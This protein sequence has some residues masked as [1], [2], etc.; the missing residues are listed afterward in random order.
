M[1]S[2]VDGRFDLIIIDPPF[3]WFAPRDPLEASM[4]DE[5]YG[6][7]GRFFAGAGEYLAD[8][9]RVLVFF[10]TSG[11]LD[12][13]H[14]LADENGFTREVLASSDLVKPELT[15]TYHAM[16]FRRGS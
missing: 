12:H 7:M 16:R 13:L 6:A 2:A 3:R 4:T 8:G 10:G 11:D 14:G 9:G 15:V 1:F 5:N